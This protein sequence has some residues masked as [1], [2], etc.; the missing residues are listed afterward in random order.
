M[1]G[2]ILEHKGERFVIKERGRPEKYEGRT[3]LIRKKLN[4][5]ICV[6]A[7]A[8]YLFL[9]YIEDAKIVEPIPQ[10]EQPTIDAK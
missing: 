4:A 6:K 1:I 10:L 5:D 3:E 2:P 9:Q 8:E 7:K